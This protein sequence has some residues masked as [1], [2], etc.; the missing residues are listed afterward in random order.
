MAKTTIDVKKV[1]KLRD[2]IKAALKIEYSEQQKHSSES[3]SYSYRLGKQHGLEEIKVKLD[4][5]IAQG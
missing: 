3:Q 4:D 2:Q 5:L 1:T